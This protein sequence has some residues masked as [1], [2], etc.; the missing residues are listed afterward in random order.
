MSLMASPTLKF[1]GPLPCQGKGPGNEVVK[2][3]M[4]NPDRLKI[5]RIGSCFISFY[6][7]LHP[8]PLNPILK[9]KKKS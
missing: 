8:D 6:Y 4:N 9:A 2:T 5:Q 1:P 7:N 3:F